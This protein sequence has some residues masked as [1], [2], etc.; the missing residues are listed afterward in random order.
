[1]KNKHSRERTNKKKQK[2][3]TK[4]RDRDRALVSGEAPDF[5]NSRIEWEHWEVCE[6]KETN[7]AGDKEMERFTLVGLGNGNSWIS[8]M[9]LVFNYSSFPTAVTGLVFS[10][11]PH[12]CEIVCSFFLKDC[13]SPEITLLSAGLVVF[14]FQGIGE[15]AYFF[16]TLFKKIYHIITLSHF[17]LLWF[18]YTIWKIYP[19][20]GLSS[21]C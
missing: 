4:R 5:W 11:P 3:R 14:F 8:N 6:T 10:K 12:G 9:F 7:G 1:M 16:F 21:R 2:N 17:S 19:N 13:L 15:T 20:S 18:R